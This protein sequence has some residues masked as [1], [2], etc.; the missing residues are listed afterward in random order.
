[1][2]QPALAQATYEDLCKLPDN[3]VGELI[4]GVLYVSQRPASRHAVASS[5]LGGRLIPSFFDG[6]GGPGG[7]IILFEPELW[8]DSATLVPDLAGWRR[9]RMP[10][11]PDVVGFELAPDWIC[12]VL[13]PS[14]ERLDRLRKMSIYGR[15]GVRHAWLLD[16]IAR[17]LEIYGLVGSDLRL[18]VT[19]HENDVVRAE[20][21]EAIELDVRTIWN[22]SLF[23]PRSVKSV[24]SA[25]PRSTE[26][27]S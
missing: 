11:V 13:S 4:E 12:E 6:T 23:A 1:M 8:F 18:E 21:F 16:P 7:W 5:I 2:L 3:V 14:T 26:E 22:P 25:A 19:H 17:T 27:P 9:E 15:E 20:P 24:K 10:E